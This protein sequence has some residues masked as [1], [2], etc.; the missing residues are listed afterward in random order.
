[1]KFACIARHR[2]EFQV[3]LMCRV[4]EVSVSG[5]Y[6]SQARQLCAPSIHATM[7]QRLML[8]VRASHAK[9]KKRYGSPKV[10][11]DLKESGIRT[12]RKR[13]ARLMREEG[14]RA[15][16]A[17]KFCV[18]TDSKH[19]HPIALNTLDR[20]FDIRAVGGVNRVWVAD[21]TYIATREGW[22][23]LAVVLDLASRRVVGWATSTMLETSLAMSA[24]GMALRQR[25][26]ENGSSMTTSLLHHSDRGSQRRFNWSLQQCQCDLIVTARSMLR[27][28]FSS[29]ASSA[30]LC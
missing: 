2:G 9:S 5:F 3:R 17:R 26:I 7:D 15:K 20:Q 14:L 13:V 10:H 6:D 28:A 16:R 22:L 19:E 1:M 18:T 23:Y 24:L 12:S 25:M 27:Q 21:I 30:A 4:L 29:R 11:D 8:H